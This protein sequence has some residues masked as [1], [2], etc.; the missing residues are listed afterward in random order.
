[1]II[2]GG[3]LEILG[4]GSF[5]LIEWKDILGNIVKSLS[6]VG[7]ELEA[8]AVFVF[9]KQNIDYGEW[10]RGQMLLLIVNI[11]VSAWLSY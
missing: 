11:L 9:W 3:E 5:A 2:V 1:M 8:L 4:T 10:S 7:R 6:D